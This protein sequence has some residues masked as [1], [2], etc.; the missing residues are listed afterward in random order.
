MENH[1]SPT[2]A[3][4]KAL[5]G[6]ICFIQSRPF[7]SRTV[8][9]RLPLCKQLRG[10]LP[11]IHERH[12]PAASAP[13]RWRCTAPNS[14]AFAKC[15]HARLHQELPP[16]KTQNSRTECFIYTSSHCGGNS[17]GTSRISQHGNVFF[18]S[19]A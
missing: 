3:G 12:P 14:A 8:F 7:D 10:P 16:A 18:F 13:R 9:T 2:F 6:F 5:L 4:L 1:C 15:L 11:R 17:Q 19:V